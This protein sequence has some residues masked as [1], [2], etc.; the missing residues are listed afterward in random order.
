MQLHTTFYVVESSAPP[1]ISLQTSVDLG[2]VKLTY[3]IENV[4]T[5]ISRQDVLD[6]YADLFQGIGLCPGT[7]KLHLK[8]DAVPVIDTHRRIPEALRDRVKEELL[9]MEENGIIQRVTEPTDWVNSMHAVEK[10]KT[11]KL[12]IVL[13][14][15]ALNEKKSRPHYPMQTLDDVTSRLTD[16][17]FFSTL[18]VTHAYW[19]VML[20][21]ESSYVTMFSSPFGRWRFLRLPLELRVHKIFFNKKWTPFSN[22]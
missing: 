8:P 12:R 14:P 4:N 15:K 18:D 5:G 22:H 16:A 9:R 19:S 13:D 21:L 1:L 10:P 11:G 6:E 17:K 20:Y 3:S 2:L 7:C